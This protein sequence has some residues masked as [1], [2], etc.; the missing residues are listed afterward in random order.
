MKVYTVM[1][2]DG[3]SAYIKKV[4]RDKEEAY[5]WEKVSIIYDVQEWD[6]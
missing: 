5:S 2:N 1:F 3:G 4:T 6:V